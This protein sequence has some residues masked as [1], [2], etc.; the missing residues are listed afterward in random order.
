MQLW[1]SVRVDRAEGRGAGREGS[2]GGARDR[3]GQ[4]AL[5]ALPSFGAVRVKN[6]P[7][8]QTEPKSVFKQACVSF[9]KVTQD[10]E[11]T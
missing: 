8:Q 3:L 1:P 4:S 11:V 6:Q 5:G 9:S 7:A 2:Q 10:D